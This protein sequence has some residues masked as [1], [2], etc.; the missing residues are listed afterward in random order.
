MCTC[1]MDVRSLA[2]GWSGAVSGE[3]RGPFLWRRVSGSSHADGSTVALPLGPFTLVG[4]GFKLIPRSAALQYANNGLCF[5][6][7]E[8]GELNS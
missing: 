7:R 1:H 5:F 4:G 3:V 8:V 2:S 6:S